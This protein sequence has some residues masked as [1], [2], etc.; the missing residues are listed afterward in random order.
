MMPRISMVEVLMQSLHTIGDRELLARALAL[1]GREQE[2][3]ADL[4]EHLAEIDQRRLYLDQACSSLFDYCH[5]RLGFSEDEAVKRMRVARLAVRRPEVLAEL[6]SGAIRLTGLFLLSRFTEAPNWGEL[7]REARGKSRRELERLLAAHFPRA[8]APTRVLELLSGGAACEAGES[9]TGDAS[10][11]GKESEGVDESR[12]GLEALVP[13]P[14]NC[15]AERGLNR[16]RR[17]A[18]G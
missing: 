17:P 1:V 16:C 2:V 7:L 6:R 4:I 9:K 12:T 8:D 18:I 13:G 15:G 14:A 5:E 10:E 11:G 3:L